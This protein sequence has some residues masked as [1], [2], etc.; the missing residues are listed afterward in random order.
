V[1]R[2]FNLISRISD[3]APKSA[4]RPLRLAV[5]RLPERIEYQDELELLKASCQTPSLFLLGDWDIH[6]SSFGSSVSM[7]LLSLPDGSRRRTTNEL[8]HGMSEPNCEKLREFFVGFETTVRCGAFIAK[9]IDEKKARSTEPLP[10]RVVENFCKAANAASHIETVHLLLDARNQFCHL[11][12]KCDR[13]RYDRVPLEL[14]FDRPSFFRNCD[15][16]DVPEEDEKEMRF[17]LEDAFSASE[18]L[19]EYYRTIQ[20]QQLDLQCLNDAISRLG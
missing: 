13:I 9:L 5:D 17:F 11:L 19:I 3:W 10:R 18:A 4:R 1:S 7:F 16:Y 20:H 14:C 6:I 12:E 15:R 2:S 8:T